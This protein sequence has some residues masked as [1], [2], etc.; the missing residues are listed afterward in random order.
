MKKS[1]GGVARWA[2]L[3]ILISAMLLP[4]PVS[5]RAQEKAPEPSPA[6]EPAPVPMP[7]PLPRLDKP[8]TSS[9]ET[10]GGIQSLSGSYV[11]FDSSVGGSTCWSASTSASFCFKTVSYSPDWEYAYNTFLKF[12]TSWNV[13]AV[14]VQGTP[15]CTCGSFG[16]FVWSYQT[17]YYEINISQPRY[18]SSGGCTCTAYYCVTATP[19]IGSGNALESWYYNGENYGSAPHWPCS[20]DIYTPSGYNTCDQW[21]NPQASIPQCASCPVN[22]P[23]PDG[24]GVTGSTTTYNW[25]DL[26][27][28]GTQVT[29]SGDDVTAG[30][31]D[32][33]QGFS[34]YGTGYTQFYV[35]TNGLISFGAPQSGWTN[36]N[37]PS[38]SA[39]NN[40]IAVAWD[41][42]Y[43]DADARIWYETKSPCPLTN[44][45]SCT[46]IEFYNMDTLSGST[47]GTWEAVLLPGGTVILQFQS[48]GTANSAYSTTGIQGNVSSYPTYGLSYGYNCTGRPAAGTAIKF[49]FPCSVIW[50]QSLSTLDT[51]A[52]A[53]QDF[54]TVYDVYD[55]YVAD[56]F[57]FGSAQAVCSIYVP[58]YLWNGGT[59][60]ANATSLNFAVYANAGGVPAGYPGSSLAAPLWSLSVAPAD[61][62]V[63]LS[64]GQGGYP[65]NV[66]LTLDSPIGVN[67]GT[68][69]LLFYPS[70]SLSAG[71]GQYGRQRSD[72]ANG[73]DAAV[74][75]PAGG[76]GFPTSWT[77]VRSAST[78]ALSSPDFAFQL[79]GYGIPTAVTLKR[80]EAWPEPPAIH[81]QW[82]TAQEIDNLG[83]NLY[84]S[85]T[86][87]GPKVKLNQVL[88]PSEVPPGSPFGAVYDWIDAFRLRSGRRYFYWLEDVDLSGVTTMHGPVR[89]LFP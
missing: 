56:D 70:L 8:T 27:S 60:I 58:G 68:Y 39:P 76:F 77:S 24:Y 61:P 11:S 80:F 85:N 16:T 34:L 41:D 66:T 63:A 38:G 79:R 5:T 69:W 72:T 44:E 13:S 83:F 36:Y 43:M 88:I 28:T 42:L 57:T 33:G 29:I 9:Q 55:I 67:P 15:S 73:Y 2:A 32:L 37:L 51:Y 75:N 53:D 23:G 65:S 82:E 48:V 46:V 87:T 31:F 40:I 47:A 78:W 86:R 35:S 12:P 45:T 20:S 50:N 62:R 7:D 74:I 64:T 6:L 30:P 25:I 84:R 3:V 81:V 59:T 10:Q 19:G 21:S 4:L 71:Y 54:E 18:H 52:Y 89:V 49:A 1:L 26:S 17:N 22:W 14:S